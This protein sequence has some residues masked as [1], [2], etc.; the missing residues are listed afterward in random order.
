MRS[1]SLVLASVA[2]FAAPA[3]ADPLR[4]M[5]AEFF[6]PLPAVAPEIEGNPGTAEKIDLGRALYFDAR[7]SASGLYSCSTCH[8]LANG[9]DDDIE[10]SIGQDGLAG[11]RNTSSVL[12]ASLNESHF[13]D[14]REVDLA[15]QGD[16]PIKAGLAMLNTPEAIVAVLNAD[17]GYAALFAAAFPGEA[18]AV[19]HDNAARAIEVFAATLITPGPFDAWLGGDDSALS[20]AEKAGLQLFMDRGCSFCHYGPTLGGAGY[21]PLGL[22]VLPGAEM[23]AADEV[24]QVAA[25]DPDAEE[26]VFRTAPLRNIALTAPYFHSGKIGDL[27]VAVAIMAEAQLGSPIPAEE[28]AG[29]VAFLNSLTGTLPESAAPP[30]PAAP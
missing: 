7:L 10:T 2:A 21:Y 3:A 18:D 17:P 27:S 1:F 6:G 30:P 9:G 5:A 20:D 14:G 16:G 22:V 4:D 25:A 13:L 11:L 24:A 23:Q 28:V 19:S 15:A 29:I 8:N 12:N 26:F